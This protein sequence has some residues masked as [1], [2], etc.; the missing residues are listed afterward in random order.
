MRLATFAEWKKPQVETKDH[1]LA[2]GQLHAYIAG[3]QITI[4]GKCLRNFSVFVNLT[5]KL[6]LPQYKN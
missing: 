1:L 2:H 4:T 6:I 3:K 5:T